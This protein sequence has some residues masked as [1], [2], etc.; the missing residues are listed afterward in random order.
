MSNYINPINNIRFGGLASGIDTETMIRDMMRIE[1]M[2]VDRVRQ[3]R[4]VV[5]WRRDAYRDITNKLRAFK[6]EF[7]DIIRPDNY[8]LSPNTYNNFK[9]T[10]I[11]DQNILS[12]SAN[13][14]AV[15]GI[16]KVQVDGLAES[17]KAVG[18]KT[19]EDLNL[20]QK[21]SD[22]IHGFER[23]TLDIN[24]AEIEITKDMTIRQV[25]NEINASKE[26]NAK[27]TYSSITKKFT[28]QTK[29]TGSEATLDI[30]SDLE[31]PDKDNSF[32]AKIGIAEGNDY[33]G[34]DAEVN[35]NID[36]QGGIVTSPSNTFT[37]DGLTFNLYDVTGK[38][39]EITI[40]VT[41]DVDASFDKIKN[42]VD[43]YNKLIE[44]INGKLFEKAYR[45][46]PPLTEMQRDDM[47]EKEI[48]KWEEKAMSGLLRND[49]VLQ[50]MVTNMRSA[51]IESVEGTDVSLSEIGITTGKWYEHGKLYID[52]GKLKKFLSENPEKVMEL[53]SKRD[54]SSY[55]PDMDAGAR[56]DR[57]KNVGLAHRISDILNDNIRTNRDRNNNKGLLLERAGIEGD[58]TEFK[59]ALNDQLKAFDKRIDTL[60]EML[61]MRE[62]SYWRQFTAMEKALQAMN[63][64]SAWLFQ[65][66]NM[67]MY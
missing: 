32:L 50:K 57:Y 55:S 39:E 17:A 34:K 9:T 38:D 2:K 30:R 33:I 44:D 28:L 54:G 37:R 51:L 10:I 16:Y 45:D 41:E 46:F 31:D 27:L 23:E 59:N 12:V 25:M 62:E 56:A 15:S 4:Q 35:I 63:A 43:S 6:D 8:M 67:D 40:R 14:D 7:F 19:Y 13:S 61:V 42:F 64:Q 47:S 52:E 53:F 22:F 49:P 36:G 1:N 48:E 29:T 21:I 24:G 11:G 60:N 66:L 18:G 58:T 5:E 20:N 26:A 65:Q 3:D